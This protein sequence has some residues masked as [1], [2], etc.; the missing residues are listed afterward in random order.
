MTYRIAITALSVAFTLS[1]CG[2]KTLLSVDPVGDAGD[3]S[4]V[5]DSDV[6]DTVVSGL[7]V[8][9]P[10]RDQYTTTRLPIAVE[11]TVESTSPLTS[12][13]WS[14]VSA[15]AGSTATN[16]PTTGER[17]LLT[18]D[19]VGDYELEFSATNEEGWTLGCEV[20]VHSVVG[21]PVAICPEGEQT[22]GVGERLELVGDAFDDVRVVEIRWAVERGPGMAF[23]DPAGE[24]VA[25]FFADQPG[26]YVASLTVVDDEMATDTCRFAIRVTAP[27]EVFCPMSPIL[28]PTRQPVSV[29]ARTATDG[30][31][32]ARVEWELISSPDGS[33]ARPIPTDA[34]TTRMT[35]DRQGSYLLRFT[36]TD[37]DGL[38]ASCDVE[39]IGTPTAPECADTTVDTRPL[40][41]T[42]I[43][44]AGVDDG[45]IVGWRWRLVGS[46]PGSAAG[47]PAPA[48]E[49]TTRFR[50]DIAGEYRLELTV[51]DDD[52]DR[53]TCIYLVR[54]VATEGL[55]IEVNWD[56]DGTDMDT[57]LLRPL[58]EGTSWFNDN[59]CYYANCS[60][61]GGDILEWGAPGMDDNPRLDLD[62]TTGFGP[63]NIN[64]DVPRPGVYRV[65]VHAFQGSGR[66]TV[67]V[68]CGGTTTTPRQTFGP[69]TLRGSAADRFANDFWRV[70][71]VEIMG[72]ATCRI[73]EL[74][75]AA[76]RPNIVAASVVQ[77]MR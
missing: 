27:P 76:G 25:S 53:D 54:A 46:P 45:S 41:D 7:T 9:C 62:V 51:T 6:P 42:V 30:R 39:V 43:T 29:T 71:D 23:I 37:T 33:S 38:T 18:P 65:G 48:G 31:G 50:P 77:S 10:R 61:L 35:P 13:G 63:E 68:Y 70:A 1:A 55:R 44:G 49:M 21:P 47:P 74:R 22:T 19:G 36:A 17:T 34:P 15:P 72:A 3:S 40:T 52:G 60:E 75:D 24:L 4:I 59:D 14:L 32:I 67:R 73:T 28:A 66:V 11:A 69:T 57:H 56:T 16:T 12:S 2:S 5:V 20:V 8:E 58:P 64:V 26:D